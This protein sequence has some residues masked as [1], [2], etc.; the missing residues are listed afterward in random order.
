MYQKYKNVAAN[1]KEGG[2]G[3]AD[4]ATQSIT[5]ELASLT[6]NDVTAER[7][8]RFGGEEGGLIGL[9]PTVADNKLRA[10]YGGEGAVAERMSDIRKAIVHVREHWSQYDVMMERLA[11]FIERAVSASKQTF[12]KVNLA[13]LTRLHSLHLDWAD[14]VDDEERKK[15]LAEETGLI[16]LYTSQ[17]GYKLIFKLVYDS[18]FRNDDSVKVDFDTV[19]TAVF[20]IELFNIQL[21]N[22]ALTQPTAYADFSGTVYRGTRV[23]SDVI[24]AHEQL[25]TRSLP[26]RYI[27]IPLSLQS[28]SRNPGKALEFASAPALPGSDAQLRLLTRVQV[29]N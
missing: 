28:A 4:D 15:M 16:R 6:V 5:S 3:G 2:E 21:F 14:E 9:S 23:S 26:D 11:K 24:A 8:S 7:A 18:V 19:V 25:F 17:E 13:I 1:Q 20:L 29:K 22:L 27:A 10:F 12:S